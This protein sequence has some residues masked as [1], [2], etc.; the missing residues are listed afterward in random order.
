VAQREKELIEAE[1]K[2]SKGRISGP[3]GAAAKLG[4][5]QQTLDSRIKVL[6]VD[7]YRFKVR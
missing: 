5:P 3:S 6:G 4:I 2:E 1:L 7:K